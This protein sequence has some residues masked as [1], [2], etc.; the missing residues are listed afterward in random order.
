MNSNAAMFWVV[1]ILIS[2]SYNKFVLDAREA[3]SNKPYMVVIDRKLDIDR[4]EANKHSDGN[5]DGLITNG[6]LQRGQDF[7]M[8]LNPKMYNFVSNLTSL[9]KKILDGL[10]IEVAMRAKEGLTDAEKSDLRKID[11]VDRVNLINKRF[12]ARPQS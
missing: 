1:A 6:E 5:L 7:A 4:Y 12:E 10:T 3:P 2:L 8:T 11:I 9:E